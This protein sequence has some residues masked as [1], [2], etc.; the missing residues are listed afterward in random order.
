MVKK[1]FGGTDKGFS[2]SSAPTGFESLPEF[3]KKAFEEAVARGSELSQDSGIFAPASL[4]GGQQAALSSL[5]QGLSP[6]SPDQ[7]QQG[8]ATF[9]DP[10]EEQV[11]Q[12]AIRDVQEVGQG[13]L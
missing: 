3:G 12:N 7:F 4:T 8:L 10:F 5:Q 2:S 6:T 13:Q 11:V 9:G 1:L